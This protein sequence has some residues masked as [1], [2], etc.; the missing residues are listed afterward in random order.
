[1]GNVVTAPDELRAH[2]DLDRYYEWD[3]EIRGYKR[4]R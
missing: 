4:A 3:A 1:L 2:P